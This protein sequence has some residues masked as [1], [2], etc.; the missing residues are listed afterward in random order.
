MR[1]LGRPS[2]MASNTGLRG[3]AV[4]PGFPPHPS[5]LP[6]GRGPHAVEHNRT[7]G[8]RTLPRGAPASRPASCAPQDPGDVLSE[9]DVFSTRRKH[10]AATFERRS[11]RRPPLGERGHRNPNLSSRP[12]EAIRCCH[13]DRVSA[14]SEWRDL[15]QFWRAS[16]AGSRCLRSGDPSTPALRAS[17]RDDRGRLT[18]RVSAREYRRSRGKG[19]QRDRGAEERRAPC[20]GFPSAN[21]HA[22][23]PARE[24]G[25]S[26]YPL[27]PHSFHV[28]RS[29][30]VAGGSHL[31]RAP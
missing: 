26:H 25:S 6:G 22:V 16:G 15:L 23:L 29:G 11:L 24:G 21:A 8:E 18:C 14:A 1:A 31:A 9:H 2:A 19:K 13:P 10:E 3:A 27:R 7:S 30:W 12:S 28:S 5:L 4:H 17:A 20:G